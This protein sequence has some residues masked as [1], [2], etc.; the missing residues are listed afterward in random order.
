MSA[1]RRL[2]DI[3]GTILPK[4]MQ[5]RDR[6]TGTGL[7]KAWAVAYMLAGYG[8]ELVD[9]VIQGIVAGRPGVGT[10]TAIP[11]LD[12][13]RGVL[14]GEIET[15]EEHA[16]RLIDWLSTARGDLPDGGGMGSQLGLAREIRGYL[17][18]APMVRVVNRHGFWT[19]I[20][21]DGTIERVRG[22]TFDWDSISN[23]ERAGYWR[24][25]WIILY[26]PQWAVDGTWGDGETWGGTLGFGMNNDA[27][28]YDAIAS[29]CRTWKAARTYIRSI[30]WSYDDTLFDP[31]VP[32]SLPDGTWGQAHVMSSGVAV[33][34]GRSSLAR[35][36][37]PTP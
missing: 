4:W 23:P 35:Y 1:R 26:Q 9:R 29:L 31:A 36:W 7:Y 10:S 20:K 13:N 30:I 15:N 24:D 32:A 6:G 28:A 21:A 8:D 2:R 27:V 16:Q 22:V 37:E 34:S 33:P 17:G 14:R 12:R 5:D 3:L 25:Q 18:N 19:T 11:Y